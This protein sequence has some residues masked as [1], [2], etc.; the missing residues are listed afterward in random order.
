YDYRIEVKPIGFG[1]APGNSEIEALAHAG[2][3]PN[4][5]GNQGF[6]AQN[7]AEL[8]IALNQIVADSIKVETCNGVDD[9]CDSF[10]DEGFPLG[11]AC[12]DGEFGTCLDNGVLVCS[13]DGTVECNA[14][15]DEP[16]PHP[17][18]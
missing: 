10:I 4:V 1:I 9:D 17:S 16:T 12:S 3:E 6:Y 13:G 14:V 7:E 8:S 2:G 11:E 18:D 5:S 15:D